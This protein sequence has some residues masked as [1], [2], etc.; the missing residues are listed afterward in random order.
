MKISGGETVNTKYA[1]TLKVILECLE[2]C[3]TC[4]D[5]CLKEEDVKMMA[6][7]IRLD[8]EC[9]DVCAFA[10]Q[11]ITRNSPFTNQ[12]LELCADVCDRCAEECAK[13]DEDH[14]KR[15]AESCRKCAEACR[16]AVA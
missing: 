5:A 7:C 4:F 12:I 1:E 11:A 10:A 14:C 8:R 16:Q 15:C 3:N 13:H 6:D 2:E 9:A